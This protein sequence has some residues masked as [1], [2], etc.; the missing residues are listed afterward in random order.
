MIFESEIPAMRSRARTHCINLQTAL[1]A[2]RTTEANR[3]PAAAKN[4][5][6]R[7]LIIMAV[8]STTR[9]VLGHSGAQKWNIKIIIRHSIIPKTSVY[10]QTNRWAYRSLIIGCIR[11][12]LRHRVTIVTNNLHLAFQ[13][14]ASHS[15]TWKTWIL[16]IK[17][18][19]TSIH[20][21]IH[22]YPT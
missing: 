6:A 19:L 9:W 18:N 16:L 21:L 2:W 22:T 4:R 13:M 3:V 10:L 1:P 17:I 5:S 7:P 11:V 8:Y 12:V 15:S 14:R 20:S